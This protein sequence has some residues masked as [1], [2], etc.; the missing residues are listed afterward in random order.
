MKCT[1]YF[2]GFRNTGEITEFLLAHLRKRSSFV[3]SMHQQPGSNQKVLPSS[4][5]TEFDVV[6]SSTVS[7]SVSM[8]AQEPL[9]AE[10]VEED[11][12]A[13]GQMQPMCCE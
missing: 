4:R 13:T 6:F 7:S 9:I 12:G 8:V 11:V 1:L 10:K 5:C 2:I 3:T